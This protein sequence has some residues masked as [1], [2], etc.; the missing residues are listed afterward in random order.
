MAHNRNVE[1]LQ[2]YPWLGG[3]ETSTDPII[4]DNQ[5]LTVCDNVVFSVQGSRKK[6]GG[7]AHY[8]SVAITTASITQTMIFVKDYWANVSNVKREYGVAVSSQGNVYRSANFSTWTK[9]NTATLT[10]SQG[11]ITSTIMNEDFILA[12]SK[13]A[14]P[15]K[16]DNQNTAA[17]LVALGGSP[18]NGN[19]VQINHNRVFLSGNASNPDRLYYS[20][21]FSH[22]SWGPTSSLGTTAGYIDVF[23]GDGDPDGITAIF[24]EVNQGGVYVAKRSHLYFVNNTRGSPS[25][26]TISL[27]SDGIGCVNQ[28]TAVCVDQNDVLFAS[29][30]GV[31]SLAQVL[32]QTA[33]LQGQYL[34]R[35]IQ[36]DYLSIISQADKNKMSAVWF[37]SL[38]SYMMTCKRAGKSS[39]E[40][41]YAYN[42]EL[43]QWYRWTSVPC[44]FITTRFNRPAG[45]IE[46]T[47]AADSGFINK[48]NQTALNDFTTGAIKMK[49]KSVVL[50]PQGIIPGE[51]QFTNLAFFFRARGNYDFNYSY[52]IDDNLTYTGTITQKVPGS[53]IL[54]T[55]KLGTGFV[56]GAVTGIKPAFSHIKGVGHSLQLTIE[57][58]GLNQDLELFG[59]AVEFMPASESQ[60]QFR[61]RVS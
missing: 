39:Y 4:C 18:P 3:L 21:I 36:S 27:V 51:K 55:T 24:P 54:G 61:N 2:L 48:L 20:A 37:P 41:I 25:T 16:W 23:P 44:N 19:L 28:N 30:R 53:N 50:Y 14:P 10:V 22:E 38:N 42:I 46:L 40:T 35:S 5:K 56:L 7:Q 58:N 12:Y 49:V 31:H 1:Y 13:T 47:T 15:K 34:S 43:K 32:S 60:N 9:F 59:L 52:T 45:Q 17:N 8:N 11:G 33:F 6:R 57:Q 26:W 29:E